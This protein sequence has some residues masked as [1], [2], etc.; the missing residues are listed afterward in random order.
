MN[1]KQQAAEANQRTRAATLDQLARTPQLARADSLAALANSRRTVAITLAIRRRVH[2]AK[3]G[4]P[5]REMPGDRSERP[6]FAFC[7]AC[8]SGA[9]ISAAESA[10]AEHLSAIGDT[11]TRRR[12][13]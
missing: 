5:C 1:R 4:G 6:G 8:V 3:A 13:A 9:K 12:Y 2:D 10:V 11:T 7:I